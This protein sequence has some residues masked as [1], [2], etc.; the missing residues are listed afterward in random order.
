MRD[1][2]YEGR[3]SIGT[4]IFTGEVKRL[5]NPGFGCLVSN[6]GYNLGSRL[7]LS[8]WK[9]SRFRSE[10][11]LGVMTTSP[12]VGVVERICGD[13]VGGHTGSENQVISLIRGV[14]GLPRKLS[15]SV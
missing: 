13:F 9:L 11:V 2:V 3:E 14:F 8:E 12:D 5:M 6:I 10:G 4:E 15:G 7:I 1:D